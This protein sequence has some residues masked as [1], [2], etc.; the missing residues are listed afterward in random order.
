[1]D[2]VRTNWF[3]SINYDGEFELHP[4]AREARAAAQSTLVNALDEEWPEDIEGVCWGMVLEHAVEVDFEDHTSYG[5]NTTGH[6]AAV[7]AGSDCPVPADL[8]WICGYDLLSREA[9]IARLASSEIIAECG[10]PEGP[11][12]DASEA[13]LAAGEVALARAAEALIALAATAR[14]PALP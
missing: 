13:A 6:S 8:D 9:S 11:A 14:R 3:F 1:M 2:S 5:H 12:W 4:T 10:R 7:E